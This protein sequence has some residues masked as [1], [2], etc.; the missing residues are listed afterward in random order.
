MLAH[1][2]GTVNLEIEKKLAQLGRN[3]IQARI[4][5]RRRNKENREIAACVRNLVRGVSADELQDALL[6]IMADTKKFEIT[7]EDIIAEFSK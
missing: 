3:V 7:E 6:N 2:S 1:N 4:W 5:N